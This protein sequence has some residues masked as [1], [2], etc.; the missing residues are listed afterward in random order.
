MICDAY[1]SVA[2]PVQVAAPRLIAARRRSHASRFSTA[3]E[4]TTRAAVRSGR[5]TPAVDVLHADAGWSAVLRV[6]ST[7][8]EEDLVLDL[9]ERDG[10]LV[11]PG[12][13]FDF[14]HEAFLVVSLLP[15]PEAFDEGVRRVLE[16]ADE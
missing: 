2:T 5:D 8:S 10:V 9:L 7:R 15:Q 14:P 12:F 16:R 3:C 1:L 6:P 4:R 11:H 13:F